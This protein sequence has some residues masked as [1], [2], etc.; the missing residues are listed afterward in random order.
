MTTE[1][2]LHEY[3]QHLGEAARREKV[4]P[5][6][7]SVK[8]HKNNSDYKC[9]TGLEKDQ[10]VDILDQISADGFPLYGLEVFAS[11]D[12]QPGDPGDHILV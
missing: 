11:K 9:I 4:R 1:Y 12:I 2:S 3:A 7:F 6:T 5:V 8:I 10:V